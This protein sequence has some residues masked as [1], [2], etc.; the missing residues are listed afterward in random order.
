[1]AQQTSIVL[2]ILTTGAIAGGRG[3]TFAGAQATDGV[4]S[5]GQACCGFSYAAAAAGEAL[6]VVVGGSVEA[7]AGAAIDGTESRLK[8]DSLGRV[9]PWTTTGDIVAARLLSVR[10]N[11]ASAAGQF[12]Q[13]IPVIG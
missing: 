10:A 4:S 8:T 11:T 12:V 3:V 7:E 1:M 13:V 2:S 5:A 9:I 6:A